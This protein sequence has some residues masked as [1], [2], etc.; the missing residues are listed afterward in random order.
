MA[1]A[2]VLINTDIGSE[3]SVMGS[4]TRIEGV[5]EVFMLHGTYAIIAK[6]KGDTVDVLREVVT[7][8]LRSVEKI[9]STLTLMVSDETELPKLI[10]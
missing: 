8:S 5:V 10:A 7:R 3:A 1:T 6:V 4:L 2:F 9:K